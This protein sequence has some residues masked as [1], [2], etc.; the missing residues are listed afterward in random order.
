M[1]KKSRFIR[2]VFGE[3]L[4]AGGRIRTAEGTK[5]PDL[6]SGPF[7]RSGTPAFVQRYNKFRLS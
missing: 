2:F 3:K 1:F 7:D 5:P 4:N 6:E